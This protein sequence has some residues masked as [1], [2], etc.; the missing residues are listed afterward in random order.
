MKL[1]PE[2]FEPDR[3]RAKCANAGAERPW[4]TIRDRVFPQRS[5][6]QALP[7]LQSGSLTY[8]PYRCAMLAKSVSSLSLD[9]RAR[10][11]LR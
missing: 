4:E 7:R 1:L 3:C 6:P 2:T 9:E 10:R 5:A 8:A 11:A